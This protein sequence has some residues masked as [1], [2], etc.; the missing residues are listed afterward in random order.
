MGILISFIWIFENNIKDL[1]DLSDSKF[2]STKAHL[3]PFVAYDKLNKVLWRQQLLLLDWLSDPFGAKNHSFAIFSFDL[4]LTVLVRAYLEC[5]TL[6]YSYNKTS[7]SRYQALYLPRLFAVPRQE[8]KY[9][10]PPDHRDLLCEYWETFHRLL[11]DRRCFL[12][13]SSLGITVVRRHVLVMKLIQL[14]LVV[15]VVKVIRDLC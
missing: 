10:H 4:G 3:L 7:M 14:S 12:L 11:L 6:N 15:I 1:N 13:T 5:A 8:E 2:G 9:W